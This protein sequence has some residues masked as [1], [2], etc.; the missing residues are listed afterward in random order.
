MG[1]LRRSVYAPEHEHVAGWTT[2]A[3]VVAVSA[4]SIVAVIHVGAGGGVD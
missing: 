3:A 4:V 2:V 1:H